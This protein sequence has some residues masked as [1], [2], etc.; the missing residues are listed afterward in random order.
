MIEEIGAAE[1]IEETH[2]R[3]RKLALGEP[4]TNA[5]RQQ[6][7]HRIAQH[8]L[9]AIGA[10]ALIFWDGEAELDHPE[11]VIR[12]QLLDSHVCGATVLALH[13]VDHPSV[14]ELLENTPL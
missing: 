6:P 10:G 14:D 5:L 11:I 9:D 7:L 2:E 3:F 13:H 8:I 4:G 12:M 1:A